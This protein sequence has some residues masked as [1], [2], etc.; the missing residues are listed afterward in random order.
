M[1]VLPRDHG[2]QSYHRDH[3]TSG[4]EKRQRSPKEESDERQQ[5]EQRYQRQREPDP[6][7]AP[8]HGVVFPATG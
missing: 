4:D 1:R 3:E 5:Q 7:L 8:F 6:G 2:D